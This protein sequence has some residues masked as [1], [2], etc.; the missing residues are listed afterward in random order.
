MSDRATFIALSL[1]DS[2][3]GNAIGSE[4]SELAEAIRRL[5]VEAEKPSVPLGWCRGQHRESIYRQTHYHEH[6]EYCAEWESINK[7]SG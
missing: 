3:L 4:R 7:P 1:T 6:T 5:L 2:V